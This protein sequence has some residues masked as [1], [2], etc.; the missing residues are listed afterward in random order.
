MNANPFDL[1]LC[2]PPP[3]IEA[4]KTWLTEQDVDGFHLYYEKFIDSNS[5]V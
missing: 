5:G 2:G 4:V 1:Y 3:M